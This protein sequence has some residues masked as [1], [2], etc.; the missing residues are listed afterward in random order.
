[1][2]DV[3]VEVL[4]R[5]RE[6][7]SSAHRC[8]PDLA[9]MY[10]RSRSVVRPRA[11]DVQNAREAFD[12]GFRSGT[13]RHSLARARPGPVRDIPDPARALPGAV[14]CANQQLARQPS[15]RRLSPVQDQGRLVGELRVAA[16]ARAWA[17]DHPDGGQ[18]AHE[19]S[20][21]A[22]PVLSRSRS[23]G[24]Y[25]HDRGIGALPRRSALRTR[26]RS[27]PERRQ[28]ARL[29]RSRA[30]VHASVPDHRD[31]G[32]ARIAEEGSSRL[33]ALVRLDHGV[34]DQPLG[35][36]GADRP[37]PRARGR[38]WPRTCCR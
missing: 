14:P 4:S 36:T 31:R 12:D 8:A 9:P 30:R 20:Q 13:A 17:D 5:R 10:S 15:R 35:R 24:V 16:R 32:D 25:T 11:Y 37:W 26:R 29:A 18:G 34:P 21:P 28:G 7:P 33:R 2:A 23:R 27:R 6:R 38:N 19:A 1:M 3:I 22:E